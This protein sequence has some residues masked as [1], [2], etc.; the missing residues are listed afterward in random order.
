MAAHAP[1]GRIY[2][3]TSSY[4]EMTEWALPADEQPT[5]H[6]AL[7]HAEHAKLPEA[8]F[9][10][11]ALWRNFQ[12]RYRE[13]NDLHKQML[14][15][16]EEVAAMPAGPS[17]DLALDHLY[18]GQ[19]NDCYWH[20]WFGGVYIVHMRMVTL[21]ELIAAED[22]A[23]GPDGIL[24]GVADYDLD[25]IDEVAIGTVGQTVIVDVAEGAGIS[26]WDLRA[27]RLALASVL[28]R[29]PEAY[30]RQIIEA[31]RHEHIEDLAAGSGPAE[32]LAAS[33]E[34]G[35]PASR[36]REL[37]KLIVYDDHE[38]RSGLVRIRDADGH[39]VG[40][41]DAEEWL[42]TDVDPWAV[43]VSRSA[44]GL[45][46]RKSISVIGERMGGYLQTAIVV[47]SDAAFE[48]TLELEWN[49]NLLGGGANSAAY[50]RSGDDEWRHDSTGAESAGSELLFGNTYEGVELSL[51]AL[52]E[53]GAEWFPVETVSNS[54]SG[55]EKV[56][57]GSCLIQR[58]PLRLRA[59]ESATLTTVVSFLQSRDYLGEETDD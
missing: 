30:H 51:R 27:S 53:T 17:R 33:V 38:R 15:T 39:A 16:S 28:R 7:E 58:W 54:E 36:I 44:A 34:G 4:V 35:D 59:G 37:S 13:V 50:Y 45:T 12:A 2:I 52:P 5:F 20:G 21:A 10:R 47:D 46:V 24:S 31:A 19:S 23:L 57:Q 1:Q 22:L 18:R 56:Y 29:R 9:M 26:S 42:V 11:G 41:F 48:G 55:F 40:A 49:L 3:P 43:F 6:K 14:R 25:G 8:R 32:Q